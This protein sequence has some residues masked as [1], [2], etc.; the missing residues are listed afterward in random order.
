MIEELRKEYL[1]KKDQE[2]TQ[3]MMN[4]IHR[5][6][7]WK[8]LDDENEEMLKRMEQKK[9]TSQDYLDAF[10]TSAMCS[11]VISIYLSIILNVFI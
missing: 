1:E 9:Y 4:A 7:Y 3:K 2:E 8:R 10:L 11:L 5:Q 6:A